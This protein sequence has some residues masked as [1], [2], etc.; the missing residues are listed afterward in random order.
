MSETS[1]VNPVVVIRPSA[2]G[3]SAGKIVVGVLVAL[4]VLLAVG[5]GLVYAN[6]ERSLAESRLASAALAA[7]LT[8]SQQ[9]TSDRQADLEG[10]RQ[11]L[12]QSQA[13][14][15]SAQANGKALADQLAQSQQQSQQQM[16]QAEAKAKGLQAEK[17]DLGA[18]LA[19]SEKAVQ[20][21]QA[22]N[23][24]LGKK[25]SGALAKAQLM[26]EY[27]SVQ[28]DVLRGAK[29]EDARKAITAWFRKLYALNDPTID[30][31]L[32]AYDEAMTKDPKDTQATSLF[33]SKVMAYLSGSVVDELQ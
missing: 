12:A 23:A 19:S 11:Q 5:A 28:I 31:Y 6:E 25:V 15:A 13:E 24:S 9:E 26:D 22:K 7:Q 14:T 3:S 18:R 21:V 1:A 30:G 27:F 20:D 8:Q 16:Q 10:T 17:D 2:R 33:L 32:D 4:L 29:T